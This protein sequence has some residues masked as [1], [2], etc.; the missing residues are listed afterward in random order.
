[1][2]TTGSR[3]GT[4]HRRSNRQNQ[5]DTLAG[6]GSTTT[7]SSD[8]DEGRNELEGSMN[9]RELLEIIRQMIAD[10]NDDDAR[11]RREDALREERLEEDRRRNE[12]REEQRL[13]D[14]RRA[15]QRRAEER[16][17]EEERREQDR[18]RD[19]DRRAG[20]PSPNTRA[21]LKAIGNGPKLNSL[22]WHA[23]NQHVQISLK[24]L[25]VALA[26]LNGD[27]TDGMPNYCQTTEGLLMNEINGAIEFEGPVRSLMTKRLGTEAWTVGDLY[28]HLQR[29]LTKNDA[30]IL[31]NLDDMVANVRMFGNDVTKLCEDLDGLWARALTVNKDLGEPLKIST[32]KAQ[33]RTHSVYGPVLKMLR[34]SGKANDYVHVAQTLIA[35]QVELELR[36]T[37]RTARVATESQ[38]GNSWRGR[39]DPN[40]P[41]E[42]AR[43]YRCNERGHI[44]R[45]CPNRDTT[46]SNASLATS[47][48]TTAT[49]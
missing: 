21:L 3:E 10:K 35:E 29:N 37:L 33:V 14:E 7:H 34:I 48:P 39:R 27:L 30:I 31:G 41:N 47:V 23:W 6:D 25:P 13:A 36:P 24:R 46:R 32:L 11:R 5:A 49:P 40:R 42:P 16:R 20:E 38:H 19:E 2:P 22:N 9:S 28:K 8:R 17:W 4:G 15:D 18:R 45:D 43:C 12:I 44:R 26:I 1:M